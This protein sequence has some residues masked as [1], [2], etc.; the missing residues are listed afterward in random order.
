[1]V[2]FMSVVTSHLSASRCRMVVLGILLLCIARATTFAASS[3]GVDPA[4]MGIPPEAINLYNVAGNQTATYGNLAE[5][6]NTVFF[7][8]E[9]SLAIIAPMEGRIL[10]DDDGAVIGFVAMPPSDYLPWSVLVGG[11]PKK[12]TLFPVSVKIYLLFCIPFAIYALVRLFMFLPRKSSWRKCYH[13]TYVGRMKAKMLYR[14]PQLQ[15]LALMLVG[16]IPGFV[17]FSLQSTKYLC[18]KC[19]RTRRNSSVSRHGTNSSRK[20]S[21][22]D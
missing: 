11:D 3:A 21:H 10:F 6:L 20:S 12:S 4:V 18:P 9:R 1:M 15:C 2:S 14:G 16:I 13:C 17:Y 19:G 5:A 7:S 8:V 22:R